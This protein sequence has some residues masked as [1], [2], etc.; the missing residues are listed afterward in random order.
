MIK[1]QAIEL[2][3]GKS[4][5]SMTLLIWQVAKMHFFKNPSKVHSLFTKNTYSIS[6]IFRL[7]VAV[8]I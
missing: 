4:N 5:F 2:Y 6:L 3:Y 1:I 8:Y 7:S